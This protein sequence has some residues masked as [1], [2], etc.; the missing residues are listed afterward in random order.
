M[1]ASLPQPVIG[2]SC[3]S[4]AATDFNVARVSAGDA[5]PWQCTGSIGA[6]LRV[7]TPRVKREW[8]WVRR[9][10]LCKTCMGGPGPPYWVMVGNGGVGGAGGSGRQFGGTGGRGSKAGSLQGAGLTSCRQYLCPLRV[11][12]SSNPLC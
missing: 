8:G 9:V 2:R 12:A 4:P 11:P 1:A 6:W 3:L 7:A 10:G 5:W